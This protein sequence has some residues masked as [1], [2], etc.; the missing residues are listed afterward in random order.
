[1]HEPYQG[2]GSELLNDIHTHTADVLE[3]E[4]QITQGQ[5]RKIARHIVDRFR[6]AFGGQLIYFPKGTQCDISERDEHLYAE[7]N[8]NN[9]KELAKKYGVTIQ[10]VYKRLRLISERQKENQQ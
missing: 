1:M 3:K 4:S 9:Q 7:F 5:S 6:Q 10:Q 8:G 2:T